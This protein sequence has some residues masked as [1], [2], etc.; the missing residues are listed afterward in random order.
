MKNRKSLVLFLGLALI[1]SACKDDKAS[2]VQDEKSVVI[3]TEDQIED[4]NIAKDFYDLVASTNKD[5][6]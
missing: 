2:K 3:K 1:F 6:A 5:L 4:E